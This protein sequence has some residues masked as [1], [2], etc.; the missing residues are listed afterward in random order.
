MSI[1]NEVKLII[2]VPAVHR[3][4]RCKKG[5]GLAHVHNEFLYVH[6]EPATTHKGRLDDPYS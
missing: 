1:A 5:H 6:N 4:A 2:K 3:K